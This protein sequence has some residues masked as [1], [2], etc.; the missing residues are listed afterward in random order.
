M[1]QKDLAIAKFLLTVKDYENFTYNT[2]NDIVI[3]SHLK[4]LGGSEQQ[5][6]KSFLSTRKSALLSRSCPFTLYNY[7][8]PYKQ[9]YHYC[10][11]YYTI[12]SSREIITA[13]YTFGNKQ[14]D[15]PK[16]IP[17]DAS[18]AKLQELLAQRNI[19]DATIHRV[20]Y[21]L[22]SREFNIYF[23][24]DDPSDTFQFKGNFNLWETVCLFGATT[25]KTEI[26]RSEAICGNK[27]AYYD[28][29]VKVKH[30]VE[31]APL[32]LSE[33]QFLTQLLSS[34]EITREVADGLFAPVII[35]DISSEVSDNNSNPIRLKFTW[36]YADQNEFLP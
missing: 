31:T 35:S 18:Y 27:V 2:G 24:P 26:D 29:S 17:T 8:V 19:L 9:E 16:I 34:Q 5:L 22:D 4:S 11:I 36:T 30:E 6:T 12:P 15:T 14:S 32:T 21:Y 10:D 25:S 28:T 33:A 20:Y 23:T 3:Y 7:A 1:L 13:T